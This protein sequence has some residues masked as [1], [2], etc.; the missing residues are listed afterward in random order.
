MAVLLCK[1][2]GSSSSQMSVRQMVLLQLVELALLAASVVEH[3]HLLACCTLL[4]LRAVYMLPAVER[5]HHTL[6]HA[7][8]HHTATATAVVRSRH[9]QCCC[10]QS[11]SICPM[12][13]QLRE[14]FS[15]VNL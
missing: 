5:H 12:L 11:F 14:R 2:R 10:L 7:V 1:Q 3:D 6:Q 9:M 13:L 4:S 15:A 8:L